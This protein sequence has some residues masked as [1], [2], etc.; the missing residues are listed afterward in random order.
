MK[1][2]FIPL[3]FLVLIFNACSPTTPQQETLKGIPSATSTAEPATATAKIDMP[4]HTPT[5]EPILL[6]VDRFHSLPGLSPI[7][8]ENSRDIQEVG[9]FADSQISALITKDQSKLVMRFESGVQIYDLP[10]LIPHP[11]LELNLSAFSATNA[12]SEDGKYVARTYPGADH[13]FKEV[14]SIWDTEIQ[15]EVCN[16][17]MDDLRGNFFNLNIH[18]EEDTFSFYGDLNSSQYSVIVWSLSTCR[19]VFEKKSGS[20]LSYVSAD[21]KY[22]AV[23]S[24]DQV[25]IF[26]I[27]KNKK[28][29]IGDTPD[30][31]GVGILSS[32]GQVIVSYPSR[33]ILYDLTTG[34]ETGRF[35]A[36]LDDFFANISF[37]NDGEW[38]VVEGFEKNYFWNSE[39]NL[40]Y[41]IRQN[42]GAGFTFQ[43][44][45]V[46][47]DQAIFSIQT[48]GK[49]DL[50]EYGIQPNIALSA[51][52]AFVSISPALLP[53]FTDIYETGTGRK[54]ISLPNEQNPI[55]L[56]DISFI[57]TNGEK[58]N[59]FEFATGE[60]VRS[61]D[62]GYVD[63]I[64]SSDSLIVLW[65]ALG[66]INSLNFKTGEFMGQSEFSVFP[67]DSVTYL[68]YPN[69]IPAWNDAFEEGFDAILSSLHGFLSPTSFA[70]SNDRKSGVQLNNSKVQI[71]NL[72]DGNFTPTSDQLVKSYNY[73]LWFNFKFSPDNSM[74]A[75]ATNSLVLWDSKSGAPI[76]NFSLP[77]ET[78]T[79]NMQFSTDSTKLVVS[80]GQIFTVNVFG[81]FTIT[82]IDLSAKQVMSSYKLAQEFKQNGCNI[83]L[84]FALTADGTQ[85]ITLTKDC[86]IGVFDLRNFKEIRSFG[87]PYSDV[88]LAFGLSPDGN[89]LAVAQHQQLVLWDV[90]NGKVIK[91]LDIPELSGRA[92]Y[93]FHKIV[94]S[95]D[96]KAIVVKSSVYF[97]SYSVI[98]VWGVPD[99]P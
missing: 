70:I 9:S 16:I 30:P 20:L 52:G 12:T 98:T 17:K 27:K 31:R 44:G 77:S 41:A 82:A 13:P 32:K 88:S 96:G 90:N 2:K 5:P 62:G 67:L 61:I 92:D 58:I 1:N 40:V 56:D 35:D 79:E 6:P 39:E 53:T 26:E 7:T 94:F 21:G 55:A 14:I 87:D 34:E 38:V 11:F 93:Y 59:Y 69:A 28:I 54:I 42:L 10:D 24:Q 18:P 36:D 43:N 45:M 73:P 75:G 85:I 64:K 76:M 23:T 29:S 60:L 19:K 57:T 97:G 74:I 91:K 15:K 46:Q 47:T 25:N 78:S 89:I 80:S 68:H 49:I 4:T 22:A 81:D 86:R 51:D 99:I 95:S 37:I 33:T 66:K 3:F 65:D 8:S 50:A 63:G 72:L 84:P 83:T 48:G 71:F